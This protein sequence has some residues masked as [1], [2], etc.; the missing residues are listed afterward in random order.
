MDTGLAQSCRWGYSRRRWQG[1]ALRKAV[2]W[3]FHRVALSVNLGGRA[4][5]ERA[6]V[7]SAIYMPQRATFWTISFNAIWW[8]PKFHILPVSPTSCMVSL[9]PCGP[10]TAR[11]NP[12][13]PS[14]CLPLLL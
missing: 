1:K 13:A 5:R 2:L 12:V 11:R 14:L 8:L 9:G 3:L 6:K 7:W 4:G 10:C